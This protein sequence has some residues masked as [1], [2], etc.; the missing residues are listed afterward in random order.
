MHCPTRKLLPCGDRQ[1]MSEL[2]TTFSLLFA[3]KCS[4]FITYFIHHNIQTVLD[5]VQRVVYGIRAYQY[6]N[7]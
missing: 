4:V 3:E 2:H 1:P 5:F 7:G 6:R